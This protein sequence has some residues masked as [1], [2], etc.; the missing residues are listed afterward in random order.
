MTKAVI[1]RA[2]LDRALSPSFAEGV[3]RGIRVR[4]PMFPATRS[5]SVFPSPLERIRLQCLI[6][7]PANS[8]RRP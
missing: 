4:I 2:V 3:T 8:R 7:I 1:A 6:K 5:L